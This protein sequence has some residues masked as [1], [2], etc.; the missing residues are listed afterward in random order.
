MESIPVFAIIIWIV[1]GL[2]VLAALIAI[3][4]FGVRRIKNYD[5]EDFEH[6]SN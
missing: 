6:R 1:E 4:Y 2:V 3:I 5:K